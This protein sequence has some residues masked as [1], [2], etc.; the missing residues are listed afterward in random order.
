MTEKL[1]AELYIEKEGRCLYRI[2]WNR[3]HVATT[4]GRRGKAIRKAWTIVINH[5]ATA[6]SVRRAYLAHFKRDCPDDV[7]YRWMLLELLDKAGY[8]E[9]A[10][11]LMK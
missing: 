5:H 9:T 11:L 7:S 10:K 1:C 2:W 6:N 3:R 8:E 4:T